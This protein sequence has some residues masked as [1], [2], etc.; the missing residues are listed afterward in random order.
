MLIPESK[1]TE[2]R[3]CG[4]VGCGETRVREISKYIR[5]RERWCIGARCMG[6]R[7]AAEEMVDDAGEGYDESGY[8]GLAGNPGSDT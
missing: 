4:P 7:Y 5:I 1:V 8:C 6:W 3:C 2:M